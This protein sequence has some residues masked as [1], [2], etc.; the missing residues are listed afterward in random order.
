M[1]NGDIFP[2]IETG[3]T[4]NWSRRQSSDWKPVP[5]HSSNGQ[6]RKRWFSERTFILQ[7]LVQP[8]HF[9]ATSP[10]RK[11]GTRNLILFKSNDDLYVCCDKS[12]SKL[13]IFFISYIEYWLFHWKQLLLL[14]FHR[15][16]AND[17]FMFLTV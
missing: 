5:A 9:P 14:I 10:N 7:F 13:V 1:R 8:F 4:E 2:I 11:N 16:M 12:E 3:R 15:G 6:K 17:L